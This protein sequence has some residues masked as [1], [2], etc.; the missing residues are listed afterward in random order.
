MIAMSAACSS[1]S[2]HCM[3]Y[4]HSLKLEISLDLHSKFV[5]VLVLCQAH[6]PSTANLPEVLLEC[7]V[8]LLDSG[9]QIWVPLVLQQQTTAEGSTLQ[10]YALGMLETTNLRLNVYIIA[11]W[12]KCR[13]QHRV[14]AIGSLDKFVSQLQHQV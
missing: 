12:A 9:L 6:F 11:A 5:I 7:L 4:P 14:T 1:K 10:P 13:L 8:D 3:S 2:M